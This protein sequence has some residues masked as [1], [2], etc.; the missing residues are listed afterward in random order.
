M[1]Y[2]S[3]KI[4][5]HSSLQFCQELVLRLTT[6]EIYVKTPYDQTLI[7][8][9][10][11][12]DNIQNIKAIVES[13]VDIPLNEQKFIFA[14]KEIETWKSMAD[15]KIYKNNTI[16][17]IWEHLGDI[18]IFVKNFIGKLVIIYVEPNDTI[19]R[20]KAKIWY[21]EGFVLNVQR[22]YLKGKKQ[23]LVQL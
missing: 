23:Q 7:V 8:T 2:S 13:K 10:D 21:Q 5:C 3:C 6:L 18:R 16:N 17:L 19:L 11:T 14:A 15:C 4:F 9:V 12:F 22:L 1:L 20:V